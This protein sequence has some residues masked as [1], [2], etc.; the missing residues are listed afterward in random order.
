MNIIS[1][2]LGAVVAYA[3]ILYEGLG[4]TPGQKQTTN[5]REKVSKRCDII[6]EASKRY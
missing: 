5:K 3:T 2:L 1:G 4:S 6:E